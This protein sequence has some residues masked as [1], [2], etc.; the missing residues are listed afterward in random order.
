ML[1]S[2][3]QCSGRPLPIQTALPHLSFVSKLRL[4]SGGDRLVVPVALLVLVTLGGRDFPLGG[5]QVCSRN[6]R[7]P[8]D[9]AHRPAH[10]VQSSWRGKSRPFRWS[11]QAR[12]S[13]LDLGR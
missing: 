4:F 11:L 8:G 9:S 3:P 2:T 1:L 6:Q 10:H 12:Q 7:K 5:L 13:K